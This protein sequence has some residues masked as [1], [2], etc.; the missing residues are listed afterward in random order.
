MLVGGQEDFTIA[1]KSVSVVWSRDNF[2]YNGAD[3]FG[4]VRAYFID[5]NGDAVMLTLRTFEFRNVNE[6]GYTFDV[7]GAADEGFA[8][9][10]YTLIA[11]PKCCTSARWRSPSRQT[12]S[13]SS[14]AKTP[15]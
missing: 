11:R 10:N 5:V 14:T 7:I 8:L 6:G 4:S 13:R 1:P 12:T 3:Q 9:A 2:T 15:R